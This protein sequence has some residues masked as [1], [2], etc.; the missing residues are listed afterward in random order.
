MYGHNH[1]PFGRSM[2]GFPSAAILFI[3]DHIRT[4]WCHE[5]VFVGEN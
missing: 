1:R 5:G 2:G 3:R 4:E